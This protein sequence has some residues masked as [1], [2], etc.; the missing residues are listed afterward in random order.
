MPTRDLLKDLCVDRDPEIDG[1]EVRP[2]N[3]SLR[4]YVAGWMLGG[5]GPA[6]AEAE[7]LYEMTRPGLLTSPGHLTTDSIVAEVLLLCGS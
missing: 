5:D 6:L 7:R 1:P 2:H 3:R 4:L